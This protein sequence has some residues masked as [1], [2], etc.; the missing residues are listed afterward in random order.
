MSLTPCGELLAEEI[1]RN[2]PVPFSRFMEIALY[3]PELGYYT[4]GRDPFG[5]EGDFFTAVQVQP[6]FGRIVASLLRREVSPGATVAD[7]GAGRCEMRSALEEFRYVPVRDPF[8]PPP[9]PFSGAVF[10]NE[11]FDALPVDAAARRRGEW[12]ELRAGFRGG[13]FHWIDFA[14]LEEPWLSYA[15]ELA[16]AFDAHQDAVVELPVRLEQTAAAIDRSL[17]SGVLLAIDYGYTQKEIVRFP[18]G[19]LMSY[20]RHRALDDVLANPGGQDITSHVPFDHLKNVFENR[21]WKTARFET[22]SAMLLR[23]GE[24]DEFA[25]ALRADSEAETLKLRLQLKTLLFG[26]GETFRALWMRK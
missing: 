17:A 7:W 11:L 4:R 19:T 20:R 3:H 9:A 13:S 5:K 22:L 16:A 18:R 8:A 24:P 21:G 26:M 23:A 14:P 25:S 6:V 1:R 2:G 15:R 12:I 10:A